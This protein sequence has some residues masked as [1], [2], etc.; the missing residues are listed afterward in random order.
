MG[1]RNTKYIM[2]GV[3]VPYSEY[4]RASKAD[5]DDYEE[6]DKFWE[7][8][9]LEYNKDA[10]Y[11]CISDGMCG[12]YAVFGA[13]LARFDDGY[14]QE[15]PSGVIDLKKVFKPYPL[16]AKRKAEIKAGVEKLLGYEVKL[17][18]LFVNHYS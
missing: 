15:L 11:G 7:N 17:K 6:N 9:G 10:L 4:V 3:E 16:T 2:Y 13:V 12:E 18:K 1:V 8:Y 5:S 14:G